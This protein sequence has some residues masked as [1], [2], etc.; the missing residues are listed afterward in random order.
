MADSVSNRYSASRLEREGLAGSSSRN[1]IWLILWTLMPRGPKNE[2]QKDESLSSTDDLRPG[3]MLSRR[4]LL[5]RGFYTSAGLALSHGV[6]A[7]GQA[8][9]SPAQ[10]HSD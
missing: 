10:V 1:Q 2:E 5:S 9:A 3:P 4:R 6:P 8:M 7:I